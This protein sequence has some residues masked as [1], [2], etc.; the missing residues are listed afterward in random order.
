MNPTF[1]AR[2][3]HV[4]RV[5]LLLGIVGVLACILGAFIQTHRF[6]ISYLFGYLF[7]LGLTLGCLTVTMIHNLT[8]GRWGYPLRRFLEAGFSTLPVMALLFVPIFFGLRT[9]YPWARPEEAA[10]DEVIRSRGFYM[11]TWAFTLRAVFYFALWTGIAWF[12][13]KWSLEQDTVSEAAPTRRL[14]TLSGLGIVLFPLTATFAYV[15]WV[16]STEK[17]WFSTM[18][19][20]IVLIGQILITFAFGVILLT[21]FR[22]QEVI[23]KVVTRTHYH[24]LGN[25]LLAFVMFWTYVSFGQLLI[26][27]SGNLPGEIVWYLHRIAGDWKWIIALL[28]LFHFFVPFF[29]LL[30]RSVKQHVLPLTTLAAVLFGAHI[31]EL[32]W[33]ITPSYFPDGIHLHWL[34]FATWI[35][36]GGI[37]LALFLAQLKSA[38]LLPQHDPGELFAFSYAHA[39]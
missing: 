34:D 36:I 32:Y 13:R 8:G 16:M 23:S 33:L 12:L 14:R 6:F 39:H 27:Y 3:N 31:A 37:W 7:W 20:V 38:P 10:I 4:Q 11:T 18:F 29:L 17:A 24:H 2:L 25:L 15:D 9:L 35:G 22:R 26:I 1:L 28:A 19:G 30:F 21:V 5:S